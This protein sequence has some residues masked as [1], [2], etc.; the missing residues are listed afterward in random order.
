M[1]ENGTKTG[2]SPNNVNGSRRHTVTLSLSPFFESQTDRAEG[3]EQADSYFDQPCL[4]L[5]SWAHV[6]GR[7][8]QLGQNFTQKNLAGQL[9]VRRGGLLWRL[10]GENVGDSGVNMICSI[11]IP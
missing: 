3:L 4:L 1:G 2:G 6:S 10:G 9:L 8:S 5:Q 7:S 11:F